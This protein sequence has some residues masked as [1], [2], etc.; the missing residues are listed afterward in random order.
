MNSYKCKKKS[1]ESKSFGS[2]Y[3]DSD[4]YFHIQKDNFLK[5]KNK[6]NNNCYVIDNSVSSIKDVDSFYKSSYEIYENDNNISL[7][8][9]MN[10]ELYQNST[11]NDESHTHESIKD[12]DH[13]K[14]DNSLKKNNNPGISNELQILIEKM[15]KSRKLKRFKNKKLSLECDENINSSDDIDPV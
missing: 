1:K 8:T 5:K 3:K 13:T 15:N 9:Y 4:D 2:N 10:I 11:Y 7:N 12:I 6:K 14:N